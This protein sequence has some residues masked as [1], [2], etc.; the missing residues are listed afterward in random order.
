MK[1]AGQG[2]WRQLHRLGQNQWVIGHR[3][4]SGNRQLDLVDAEGSAA[5]PCGGIG[6]GEGGE[7]LQAASLVIGP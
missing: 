7:S 4:E 6:N 2:D 5:R 1:R 3:I